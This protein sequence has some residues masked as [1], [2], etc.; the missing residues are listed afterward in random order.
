[1]LASVCSEMQYR[2]S[3]FYC[4]LVCVCS[5]VLSSLSVT[6]NSKTARFSAG[7]DSRSGSIKVAGIVRDGKPFLSVV[8]S[9]EVDVD[10]EV[11][12]GFPFTLSLSGFPLS[13]ST[14]LSLAFIPFTATFAYD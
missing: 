2:V 3:W 13:L 7:K 4:M 14:S 10:L 9:T 1:M 11:R 8:G 6:L 12:S 5:D